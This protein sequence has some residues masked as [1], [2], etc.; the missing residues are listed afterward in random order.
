MRSA[1]RVD[2]RHLRAQRTR[3]A[4]VHALLA[5]VDERGVPPTAQDV[6]TRAK[7]A[8]RSIRLH[9]PS[10]EVLLV[11]A[12]EEHARRVSAAH[13]DLDARAPFGARLG[14]FVAARA[15]NLEATSALRR[16][17]SAMADRAPVIADAMRRLSAMRRDEVRAV[18]A[19]ELAR[20]PK[21]T[22]DALDLVTSASTWDALRREQAHG[23]AAAAALMERLVR[24]VLA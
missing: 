18:F 14:A 24:A 12:S 7:V 19:R 16:A 3:E 9:F 22:L 6:A 5:L 21:A 23:T 2:G 10:R 4:I 17:S 15:K 1:P 11:A 13:V 20:R 8:L